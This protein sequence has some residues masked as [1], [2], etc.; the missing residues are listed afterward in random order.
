[1]LNQLK[2]KALQEIRQA[3]DIKAL[4]EIYRQYFGRKGELTEILRSLKDLTE[5]ERK[6]KGRL[7]NQIKKELEEAVKEK[8]EKFSVKGG[9][10][11]KWIDVTAPGAKVPDG[12]LHPITL[13]QRQIEEIFQSMGFTVA[14]GPE[15]ESEHYNFDALNVPKDHPA[16]DIQ[17][18]FWLK[19]FDLLLRTHTSNIQARYME[20]NNPP[21]RII[22]PGRCFRHE[23][24]DAS[25]DVQFNQV[26][27]L[28]IGQDVSVADFKGVMEEFLKRFFSQDI[29][30]RLRP[31]Y[32]PFVEPGFEI[33]AR[34]K[35]QKWLELMGAGM[36]HPNVFKA[37]GYIPS[38][39]QGFA[40]G[41]CPDRLAMLKYKIDDIRLFYASDLRFLKQ[42]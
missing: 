11:K 20:K 4:E 34:R 12:H 3:K 5:E 19:D 28:M 25:H 38:K 39:W 31:G 30:M 32:F 26:E 2:Q 10:D 21:L 13:V 37:V 33:D 17:D 18:T 35:G 8:R 6:E 41:M 14:E 7:A 36:V 1:M 16:R 24:T 27:G 42:F 9:Q 22:A 23:A 15:V 40:F 29:E